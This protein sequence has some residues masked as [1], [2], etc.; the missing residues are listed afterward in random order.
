[1]YITHPDG[2]PLRHQLDLTPRDIKP[3]NLVDL[4]HLARDCF[5]RGIQETSSACRCAL[6][7]D[8]AMQAILCSSPPRRRALGEMRAGVNL[9]K[10]GEEWWLL[11]NHLILKKQRVERHRL[12]PW[13]WPIIERFLAV[14]RIELLAGRSCDALW[15]K[16]GGLPLAERGVVKR[17]QWHSE[18]RFGRGFGPH[19]YRYAVA[20]EEARNPSV[21]PF[22]PSIKLAHANPN[23]TITYLREAAVDGVAKRQAATLEELRN[24]T[25]SLAERSY[26]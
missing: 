20:I 9:Q 21:G 6:I 3:P 2:I 25:E 17:I 19:M 7:R 10:H 1:M 24:I 5:Q 4:I 22:S 26:R 8:A 13:T 23:S 14:E 12:N 11:L 16:R 18:K 15:L